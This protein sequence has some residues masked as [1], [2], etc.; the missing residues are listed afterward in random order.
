[1]V[2]TAFYEM[3]KRFSKVILHKFATNDLLLL[4]YGFD[5]SKN[6]IYIESN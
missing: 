5:I 4:T 1:M 6:E 3:I 2:S